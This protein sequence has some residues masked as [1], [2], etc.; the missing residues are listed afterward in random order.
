MNL[1]K[2]N[3]WWL[4]FSNCKEDVLEQF[5]CYV[6]EHQEWSTNDLDLWC[7]YLLYVSLEWNSDH[8]SYRL[9]IN[10]T[11]ESR[12]GNTFLYV[13]GES[14]AGWLQHSRSPGECLK[15]LKNYTEDGCVTLSVEALLKIPA[16]FPRIYAPIREE[17]SNVCICALAVCC[18]GLWIPFWHVQP[19]FEFWALWLDGLLGMTQM[20][21]MNN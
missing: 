12:V 19:F 2:G 3:S 18:I 14:N 11:T 4:Q 21:F 1:L 20:Q 17:V 6:G 13:K 16:A 10:Y 15:V 8:L 7:Q 9:V 5:C